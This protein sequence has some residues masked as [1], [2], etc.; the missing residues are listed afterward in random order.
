MSRR[1]IRVR[2]PPKPSRPRRIRI[3][4]VDVMVRPGVTDTA[5]R[6]EVRAWK[7]EQASGRPNENPETT[8]AA[9]TA[10]AEPQETNDDPRP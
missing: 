5:L 1:K 8:A 6:E 7:L 10:P 3:E 2:K 4:G 9:P